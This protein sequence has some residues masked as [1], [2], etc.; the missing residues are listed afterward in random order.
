MSGGYL[1]GYEEE[2]GDRRQPA[3]GGTSGPIIVEAFVL[4]KEPQSLEDKTL[5]YPG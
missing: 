2:G 3:Q 5:R 4:I 1:T